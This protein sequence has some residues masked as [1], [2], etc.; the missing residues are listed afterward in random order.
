MCTT[1]TMEPT[2][3]ADTVPLTVRKPLLSAKRAKAAMEGTA[4][5]YRSIADVI[6]Y[7]F[8]GF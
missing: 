8:I 2:A 4:T 1:A 5:R 3:M 6:S 7:I